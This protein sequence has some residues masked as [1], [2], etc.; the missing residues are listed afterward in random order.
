GIPVTMRGV[1]SGFTVVTA[2]QDPRTDR[3][4]D[5]DAL[6]RTGTTLVVLM[7]ASRARLISERLITGG[8]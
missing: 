2:H 4:I 1:S 8:L 3:W 7:G 5:W 6:A